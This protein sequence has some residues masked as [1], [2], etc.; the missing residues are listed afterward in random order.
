[1]EYSTTTRRDVA[2]TKKQD[3]P[4]LAKACAMV[5][6]L[7]NSIYGI[8]ST[9]HDKMLMSTKAGFLEKDWVPKSNPFFG[10]Y[11]LFVQKLHRFLD[12]QAS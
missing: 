7:R 6:V 12:L 5:D 1:M 8:V 2:T 9:F 11:E 4:L 10:T 3:I